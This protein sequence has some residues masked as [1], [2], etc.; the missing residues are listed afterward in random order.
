MNWD[1]LWSDIRYAARG[2]RRKPGFTAAVI[3]TL[4]LGIGANATM[5]GIVDQLLFRPP[6]YLLSPDRVHRIWL[7]R[8]FEREGEF[9]S[10]NMSYKRYQEFTD[11]NQTLERTA[12]FFFTDMAI[13]TG[14][15][16]REMRVGGVSSSFFGFF[17]APPVIGRYFS[18]DE[19]KVPDGTN[20][21]VLGYGLWQT[22]YGGKPDV[23]GKTIQI[24]SKT[25]TIIGVAPR[26]FTGTAPTVPAAFVPITAF[27]DDLFGS[28][29]SDRPNRPTYYGTHNM[30][31]MEMLVRRKPG[32]TEAN[33]TAE[34]TTMYRRS[35]QAQQAE[36]PG[37]TPIEKLKPRVIA[38]PVLRERGPNRGTDTK[39]ATW[40]AGVAGVVLLI[41]CANVGN[42]LLARAFG[43]R[44]EIAIRLALGV[45]R[46]QLLR[47]LVA[48]SLMLAMLGAAAGLALAQ[49][50]GGLLR[51]LLLREAD[52]TAVFQDPRVLLFT[53]AATLFVALLTGLAPALYAAH[54]DISAT[55]KAGAREGTYHRSR[56][57]MV[58]L[59]AQVAMSVLLLVGAGLFVQ[60]LLKVKTLDLGYN[61]DRVA[62]VSLEMRGVTLDGPGRVA[63]RQQL[64]DRVNALPFVEASTR[65]VTVPFYMN[66]NQDLTVPGIDSVSKLGDFYYHAG[67]PDYFR[68]MG[69]RIVRGRGLTISDTKAAS[70]VIVVSQSMAQKLWP[71]QNALGQ[72]VKVGADTMP[73]NEVVGIA[74]DIKRG[75]L[76]DEDGL[77]YYLSID[78][79]ERTGGG[80]FVRT[81][82]SA[83]SHT[84][85]LRRELQR[86]MPGA[87]YVTITPLEDILAPEMR[88]WTLGATMFA[89]FGGLALLLAALGLYSVIAYNVAQRGQELAVRSALG[90]RAKD[91]VRLILGEGLKLAFAGIV[92]GI[93]LA[94]AASRWVGPLLFEMSP[95]DP[96]ILGGVVATLFG[97]AILAGSIPAW[98]AA[99][100]D[101]NL[102]LR[103]D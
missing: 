9:S 2:L 52:W 57:R 56:T 1:A 61:P 79:A 97:V 29:G 76:T 36:N 67:D 95:N 51:K 16:A 89:V 94:L 83:K 11:W 44:R 102:A 55:L 24:G 75:S 70:K 68:V 19:D 14:E 63:L 48:E 18:A 96:A 74:Q 39:V 10:S 90:A 84:E 33:A 81:R 45:G 13:G 23:I 49:W 88:P 80:L 91:V 69:T 28:F 71:G 30:S 101:P 60:S 17:D 58:L 20:V 27:A 53:M 85:E 86:G 103:S 12:A 73:C 38:A 37:A 21:A 77:Q 34:L 35:Y 100:V 43:R 65:T 93:G 41:A 31:W 66:M 25:S 64:M 32:V 87:S 62:F 26:G 59:V 4:G 98:R 40:L 15:S 7:A 99:R 54:A 82:G 8:T 78:Q 22:N 46:G 92:I 5:F 50:G 42:L 6:S 47:Q 72:C 3:A